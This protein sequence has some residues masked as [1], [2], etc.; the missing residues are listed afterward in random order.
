[1][2]P[3]FIKFVN[4]LVGIRLRDQDWDN[5][6]TYAEGVEPPVGKRE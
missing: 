1:M 5:N 2:T 4:E 6:R 3:D